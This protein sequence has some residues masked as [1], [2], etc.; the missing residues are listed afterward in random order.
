MP[1]STDRPGPSAGTS[2]VRGRRLLIPL[3]LVWPAGLLIGA[4]AIL[5]GAGAVAGIA[6][7]LAVALGLDFLWLGVAFAT[8]D[9]DADGPARGE[10]VR[11]EAPAHPH[12]AER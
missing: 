8:D 6:L 3:G 12:A 7:G 9:G 1:S 10:L 2:P 4:V 5:A 11:E